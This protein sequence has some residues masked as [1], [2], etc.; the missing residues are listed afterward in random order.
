MN[1]GINGT[2]ERFE[3]EREQARRF[4]ADTI[5][6]DV[7]PDHCLGDFLCCV[8]KKDVDSLE[9]RYGTKAALSELSGVT[10]GYL[11]P[12]ELSTE[13][14]QTVEEQ[15]LVRPRAAVVPMQSLTHR[16]P[17]PD[18]VTAQTALT[19]PYFGSILLKWTEEAATIGETAEPK[20][21][22]VELRAWELAGYALVSNNLMQD[23]QGLEAYL[24]LLLGRAIA[25]YE[26]QAFL[27]GDGVAKPV[28]MAKCNAALTVTRNA[29]SHFKL[30]DAAAMAA[31][32]LPSSWM[33]AVWAVHPSVI[34]DVAQLASAAGG[35]G[36]QI[37]QPTGERPDARQ[38]APVGYL[39]GLPVFV[40]DKLPALGTAGDVLLFD[41]GLYVV[42]DRRQVEVAVSDQ[43]PTAFGKNQ[44]AWRV[45]H[46]VDGQPWLSQ[47]VT[48]ADGT[49]TASAYVYLT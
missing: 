40:T 27:F 35:A 36:F 44:S 10:G 25:W 29:S 39:L 24:R 21:R 18:A 4:H 9:K 31:K 8:W 19:A 26:D 13:L 49:Q 41:P 1:N 34:I 37:N 30:V 45:V 3:A 33:R 42:G 32:L 12:Q 2:L 28:G 14:Y 46:R 43:E 7:N 38:L 48:L 47:A 23:G 16:L 17:L 15:A 20:W 22:E 5:G 11:V 6:K